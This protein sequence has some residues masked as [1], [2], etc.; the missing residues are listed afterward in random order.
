ME[1]TIKCN[2]CARE[3][4]LAEFLTYPEAYLMKFIMPLVVPF[5]VTAIKNEILAR[6]I[7]AAGSAGVEARGFIDNSMAGLAHNFSIACPNCGQISWYPASGPKP[8]EAKEKNN[9]KIV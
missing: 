3:M 6:T 5:I 7:T 1:T 9:Q 2:N 4:D 8:K